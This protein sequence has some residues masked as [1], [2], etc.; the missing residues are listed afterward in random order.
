M[1]GINQL[2][3]QLDLF[4][5]QLAAQH[6]SMNERLR[7]VTEVGLKDL[8]TLEQAHEAKLATVEL[9]F[10]RC[11]T[12][13]EELQQAAYAAP[14]AALFGPGPYSSEDGQGTANIA[15]SEGCV[16]VASAHFD[17]G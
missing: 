3:N 1:D 13:L 4:A 14:A 5:A 8:K 17:R 12:A 16:L 9:L 15:A 2:T 11:D 10:A 7:E 6:D